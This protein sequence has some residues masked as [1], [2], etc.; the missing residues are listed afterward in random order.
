MESLWCTPETYV[1][2]YINY[3]QV[4]KKILFKRKCFKISEN[5]GT[6]YPNLWD[7]AKAVF[8]SNL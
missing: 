1:A 3:T 7:G 5:K 6:S 2:V 4:K 8:E